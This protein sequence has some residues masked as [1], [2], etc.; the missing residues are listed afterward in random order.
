[1]TMAEKSRKAQPMEF[2]FSLWPL[3]IGLYKTSTANGRRCL[4]VRI[5]YPEFYLLSNGLP[6]HQS[7]VT[8][9]QFEIQNPVPE[10]KKYVPFP[11]RP[12][13]S[14]PYYDA[15][16]YCFPIQNEI[17]GNESEG[18]SVTL[19]NQRKLNSYK[20]IHPKAYVKVRFPMTF[21]LLISRNMSAGLVYRNASFAE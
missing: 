6:I 16:D 17:S 13:P 19:D 21:S 5:H 3:G 1:M 4:P 11:G 14:N 8:Y 12:Y 2:V 7:P 18:I 20:F 9:E 10:L 15:S